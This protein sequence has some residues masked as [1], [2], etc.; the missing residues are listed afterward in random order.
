LAVGGEEGVAAVL[1]LL[2]DELATSMALCGA[3]SISAVGPDLLQ[4]A[5]GVL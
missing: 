1:Q 4:R 3:G 2:H 5:E